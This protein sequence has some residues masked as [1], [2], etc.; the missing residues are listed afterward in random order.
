MSKLGNIKE[1]YGKQINIAVANTNGENVLASTILP[2]NNLIIASPV[3][4]DAND[5]GTYAIFITD[6]NGT[7]IRLSYTIQT[8]NGLTTD[9]TNGDIIKLSIDN[10]T[11]KESIDGVLYVSQEDLIDNIS[12][13]HAIPHA[14]SSLFACAPIKDATL[15]PCPFS[16]RYEAKSKK[17]PSVELVQTSILSFA[18]TLLF[19]SVNC[20]REAWL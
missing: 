15:V 5:I 6:N 3:D 18:L 1:S 14:P 7:P 20:C 17:G 12:T 2:K 4:A 16:E 13:S 8:G 9:E 19:N 10:K 11:L